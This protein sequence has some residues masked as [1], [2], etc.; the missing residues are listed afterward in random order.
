MAGLTAFVHRAGASASRFGDAGGIIRPHLSLGRDCAVEND[1]FQRAK[2]PGL[3]SSYQQGA[4]RA[5]HGLI[6]A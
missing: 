1:V 4:R 5:G 2:A 3:A 6:P